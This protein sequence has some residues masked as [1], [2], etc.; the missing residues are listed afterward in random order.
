MLP[1]SSLG[2]KEIKPI[3]AY[4]YNIESVIN[5]ENRVLCVYYH[6]KGI[7]LMRHYLKLLDL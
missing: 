5:N 6:D 2:L 3:S 4:F 7:L 1:S